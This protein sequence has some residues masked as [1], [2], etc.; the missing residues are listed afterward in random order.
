MSSTATITNTNNHFLVEV[1]K[2]KWFYKLDDDSFNDLKRYGDKKWICFNKLD[3][4]NLET[5]YRQ[6]KS[7][8][9]KP[10]LIQ[11][12]EGLYEVNL[13]KHICYPI[14]WEGDK[15]FILSDSKPSLMTKLNCF[16]SSKADSMPVM[17]SLWYTDNGEP[18]DEK[19]SD[20]IEQKHID[21][22]LDDILAGADTSQV[23]TFSEEVLK[24]A[25]ERKY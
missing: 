15:T 14:Y 3:S 1:G 20:Q 16:S 17:R 25:K 18:F 4:Y 7:N 22:F 2:V 13:V 23:A 12:L 6:S 11:V 5:E 21:L 8:R 24:P 19:I 9:T 10:N